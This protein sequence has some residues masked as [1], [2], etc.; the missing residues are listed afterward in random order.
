MHWLSQSWVLIWASG[1]RSGLGTG[2]RGQSH[3]DT[4]NPSHNVTHVPTSTMD[5]K[6]DYHYRAAEKYRLFYAPL[7][8]MQN[9]I[10]QKCHRMEKQCMSPAE[11]FVLFS[12]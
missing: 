12:V 8:E 3:A 7:S 10:V 1:S 2:R 9:W 6:M 11:P 4:L 5:V